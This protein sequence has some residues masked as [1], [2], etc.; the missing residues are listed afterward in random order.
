MINFIIQIFEDIFILGLE[1]RHLKAQ[2]AG[3]GIMKQNSFWCIF[4]FYQYCSF[5]S[6][7][8]N[9]NFRIALLIFLHKFHIILCSDCSLFFRSNITETY[10]HCLIPFFMILVT[11]VELSPDGNLI[12][13]GTKQ[14]VV[15]IIRYR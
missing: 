12:A 4:I 2:V 5:Y 14:S 3:E 6:S 10:F 15:R 11:C 9:S 1:I 7:C 13:V 8:F